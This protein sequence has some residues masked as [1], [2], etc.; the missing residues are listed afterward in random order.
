MSA[1]KSSFLDSN[2][3]F[4]ISNHKANKAYCEQDFFGWSN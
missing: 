4:S 1:S 2:T 3:K